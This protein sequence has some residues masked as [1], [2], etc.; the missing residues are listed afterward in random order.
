M[1]QYR[2]GG[3]A[4]LSVFEEMLARNGSYWRGPLDRF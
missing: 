3:Y 4:I 1:P 2:G